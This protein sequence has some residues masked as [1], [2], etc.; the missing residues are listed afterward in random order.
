MYAYSFPDV[1]YAFPIIMSSLQQ[2][3]EVRASR[4]G[5][6]KVLPTPCFIQYT[7]PTQRVLFYEKRDANPFFH[8]FESLWMLAGRNDVEFVT[9]FNP[10]MAMF[11]DDGTTIRGSAYGYRWKEHFKYDQLNQ[12]IQT[13]R[14]RR[15]D[16]R[17]VISMWDPATDLTNVN[18]KD[19]PCNTHIYVQRQDEFLDITVMNRSNDAL[20][21]LLG[22]NY[23]HFSFLLEYL[24]SSIGVTPRNYNHFSVNVH[25]YVDSPVWKKSTQER[26]YTMADPYLAQNLELVPLMEVGQKTFDIDLAAFMLNP[27]MDQYYDNAFFP[28]VALPMYRAHSAYRQKG[29]TERF[30]KAKAIMQGCKATDWQLGCLQWLQRREDAHARAQESDSSSHD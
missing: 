22:S 14:I 18:S 20:W 23:V 6:V 16:R 10:R 11:S 30:T 9:Q 19:L 27:F 8:F 12:V 2:V 26:L 13:L 29:D 5:P 15:D 25:G 4:N 28:E 21:G 24:A 3:E 1:N 17:C 7:C